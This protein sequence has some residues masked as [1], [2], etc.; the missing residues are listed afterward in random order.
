M[1][2]VVREDEMPTEGDRP[3]AFSRRSFLGKLS[4]GLGAVAGAGFLMKNF[5][6]SGGD[7]EAEPAGEFPGPESI[8]HPRKDPRQEAR[9]RRSKT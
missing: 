7:Q 4:L 9:E 1:K 5:L 2:P 3:E 6:F 8:F